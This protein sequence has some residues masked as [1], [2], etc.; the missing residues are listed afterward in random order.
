MAAQPSQTAALTVR[1]LGLELLRQAACDGFE[2]G[3]AQ[4]QVGNRIQ[5]KSKR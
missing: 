4:S 1:E 3:R 5:R 2:E